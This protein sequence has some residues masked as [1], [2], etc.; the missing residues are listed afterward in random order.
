MMKNKNPCSIRVI[1]GHFSLLSLLLLLS[2]P[3]IA[4]RVRSRIRSCQPTAIIV[5]SFKAIANG[6]TSQCYIRPNGNTGQLVVSKCP[7]SNGSNAVWN[8]NAGQLVVSKR[9]VPNGSNT[10]S[11]DN[12]GQLV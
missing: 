10:V 7:V 6:T 3:H 5:S 2:C 8:D 1:R 9:I 11:N 12:A 4:R